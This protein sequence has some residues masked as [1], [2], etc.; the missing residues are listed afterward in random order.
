MITD[1]HFTDL[2]DKGYTVVANVLSK[3]ECDQAIA[4]Y[5]TWLVNFGDK[6]PK[7][8]NSILNNYN[9]GHMDTTWR[10]RLRAKPVFEQLWKT[11]KLLTSFDAIA[12]GRP[13]ED[14]AEEFQVPNKYW[15][16]ADFTASRYGLHAYQG[17][18]YLEE[19][20]KNDWT[21]QV[22]EHSHKYLN[23]LFDSNQQK[24]EASI[25]TGFYYRLEPDDV[26]YF[27]RK[28]CRV[29]RVP[30]PKG[31]LVLWDSRLV[32]ANARPMPVSKYAYTHNVLL[33][34]ITR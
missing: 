24:A 32:H 12:I 20:T 29:T 27:E 1:K 26:E 11:D 3:Q 17:A 31:G 6:F 8:F 19:Q 16:H 34:N 22:M 14:G 28:R 21:F 30:V 2:E 7:T 5:K 4:E 23:D 18:L 33:I 9:S 25:K 10:L 15:L 13:P